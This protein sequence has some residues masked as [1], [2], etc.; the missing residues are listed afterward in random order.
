MLILLWYDYYYLCSMGLHLLF[1]TYV[2]L[3]CSDAAVLIGLI[4]VVSAY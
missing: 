1:D 2:F 3:L 4:A